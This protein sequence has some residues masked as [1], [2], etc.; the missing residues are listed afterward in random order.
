MVES[1]SRM[2]IG[3]SGLHSLRNRLTRGLPMSCHNMDTGRIVCRTLCHTALLTR[4]VTDTGARTL[5]REISGRAQYL[6]QR[7]KT[8]RAGC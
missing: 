3:A 2:Q 5:R 8:E 1:L 7:E 6:R 4:S